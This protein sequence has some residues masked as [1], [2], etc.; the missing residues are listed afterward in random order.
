MLLIR[1]HHNADAAPRANDAP[2]DVVP[3]L[4]YPG[5]P[6]EQAT[7]TPEEAAWDLYSAGH[8]QRSIARDLNI[9]RRKVKQIV[10]R[11]AP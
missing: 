3:A 7:P 2:C 5:P 8:S 4:T 11:D 9:D 10:D 6:A 1:K